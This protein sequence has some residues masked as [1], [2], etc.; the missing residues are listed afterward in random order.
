MTE[1]KG[2][3]GLM[4]GSDYDATYGQSGIMWEKGFEIRVVRQGGQK[5]ST[6]Y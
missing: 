6:M 1:H 3:G 2:V 4:H 5:G